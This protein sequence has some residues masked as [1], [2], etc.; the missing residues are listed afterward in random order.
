[1]SAGGRTLDQ[2]KGDQLEARNRQQQ[3]E[4]RPPKVEKIYAATD[5][6]PS[7]ARIH[8]KGDPKLLGEE[9]PRGFLKILGGATL[10]PEEAAS[11]SGRLQL[12]EID[13]AAFTEEI[14]A[15]AGGGINEAAHVLHHAEQRHVHPLEHLGTAEGVADRHFLGRGHDHGAAHHYLLH[16]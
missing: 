2:V 9:V 12:A 4:N 16:Q 10:N 5:G 13:T 11:T 8:R 1:M 6:R 14:V 15:H 7:D 3:L